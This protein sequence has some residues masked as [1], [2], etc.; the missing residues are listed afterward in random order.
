MSIADIYVH[1]CVRRQTLIHACILSNCYDL[2]LYIILMPLDI[3]VVLGK[4]STAQ[5][6]CQEETNERFVT[7]MS[8][9]G[10]TI[11]LTVELLLDKNERGQ[12]EIFLSLQWATHCPS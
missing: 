2:T 6:K 12:Q 4:D 10:L 5:D 11:N 8:V 1:K 7:S 3:A 9:S